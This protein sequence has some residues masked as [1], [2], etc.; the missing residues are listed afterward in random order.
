MIFKMIRLMDMENKE[1]WNADYYTTA[2]F[3][4]SK[5]EYDNILLSEL[6]RERKETIEPQ[7]YKETLFNYLGLEN[8]ESLTGNLVNFAPKMGAEVKSRSKI[9]RNGDILYGKLR[10]NL[11]KVYLV[12]EDVIQGICTTEFLV[13]VPNLKRVTPLYLRTILSTKYVQDHIKGLTTGAA[14]PRIQAN[15]LLALSI[16]CP[17][18]DIQKKFEVFI[19]KSIKEWQAAKRKAD[20][21]PNLIMQEVVNCIEDGKEPM[22]SNLEFE[23]KLLSGIILYQY[24]RIRLLMKS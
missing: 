21:M 10:P 2:F 8:I 24:Y 1:K 12:T 3:S 15:D 22:K 19:L 16:P 4:V 23:R 17:S 13:M 20:K 11:N 14:L 9:F 5:S 6:V 7:S 18:L